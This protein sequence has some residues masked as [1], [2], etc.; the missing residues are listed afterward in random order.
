MLFSQLLQHLSN[1]ISIRTICISDI[2]EIKDVALLDGQQ[3][4]F[5]DQIVYFGYA[6]S[7]SNNVQPEQ[8]ILADVSPGL[9]SFSCSD[10]AAVEPPF[11]FAAFNSAKQY[12]SAHAQRSLYEELAERANESHNVDA[13]LNMA[14]LKLGNSLIFCDMK[15]RILS[16]STTIPV[17]DFLWKENVE[18]GFCNYE[19]IC[20][21]Q[22][23]ETVRK[24][25]F[26]TDAI[27]VTCPESPHRKCSSKVFLNGVQIGFVLMIEGEVSLSSAHL[28]SMR[29]VSR[30]LSYTI[31]RYQPDIVQHTGK[32]Q[33]LLDDLLIGTP[34]ERLDTS[35]NLL[36]LSNQM[37]ALCI[38]T[39]DLKK[40]QPF[41][42]ILRQILLILPEAYLTVHENSIAVL[43][44]LP[45]KDL[46]EEY[47]TQL[48]GLLEKENLYLGM[49]NLFSDISQFSLSYR[50][51]S[52]AI[53]LNQQLGNSN[54]FCRYVDLQFYDLIDQ[55]PRSSTLKNY[56]H[57]ALSLLKEHDKQTG[58]DLH[59]TLEVYLECW[60]NSKETANALFIHRNSLAYRLDRIAE[61]GNLNLEDPSLRFLLRVSY[62]IEHFIHATASEEA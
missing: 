9:F 26:T 5:S 33:Q 4:T 43:L 23:L 53:S 19:F 55:I 21:V 17:T 44:P 1:T 48:E 12:I 39:H 31:N 40:R 11:L 37:Y 41:Q 47:Q 18:K 50:Q 15:F 54:R 2:H 10:L 60:C 51:A 24:A 58:N 29:D 49:S 34:L 36:K 6:E 14:S 42:N 38:Q 35:P 27:E 13:V 22:Q 62:R 28:E 61:I 7:L 52:T 25:T 46:P 45:M 32:Y 57:P 8:C 3:T 59:H 16:H 20:A 30:A 56:I